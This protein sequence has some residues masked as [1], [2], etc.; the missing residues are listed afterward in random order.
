MK[1]IRR[2]C[3]CNIIPHSGMQLDRTNLIPSSFHLVCVCVY[4][5]DLLWHWHPSI[6]PSVLKRNV[7]LYML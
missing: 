6:T 5:V 1:S 3:V 7:L 4:F 2:I